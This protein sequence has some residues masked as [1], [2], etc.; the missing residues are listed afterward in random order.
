M[1]VIIVIVLESFPASRREEELVQVCMSQ[2][3]GRMFESRETRGRGGGLGDAGGQIDLNA[4]HRGIAGYV[5]QTW[6][7]EQR[8]TRFHITH[9]IFIR[10]RNQ[11]NL[12]FNQNF[13]QI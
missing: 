13:W 9:A 7:I 12:Y 4:R 10:P 6:G 2:K 3:G 1:K 8:P 11:S 5:L